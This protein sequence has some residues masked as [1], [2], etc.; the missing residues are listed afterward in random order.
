MRFQAKGLRVPGGFLSLC[1]RIGPVSILW[2]SVICLLTLVLYQETFSGYFLGDDLDYLYFSATWSQNGEL[3]S[4]LITEFFS[5]QER[6]AFFY[7][8]LTLCSF[9]INYVMFGAYPQ[10]WRLTNRL[11]C[12]PIIAE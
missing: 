3:A 2:S 10:G 8:P 7:R 5:P 6:G 12:N 9:A 1:S 11:L 4:R